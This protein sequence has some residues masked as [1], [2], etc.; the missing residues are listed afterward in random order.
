M[1]LL[2]NMD[3]SDQG[4]LQ[5][6]NVSALELTKKF[7]TPL[8]VLD[9]EEIEERAIAYKEALKE[10]YPG[11]FQILYA[12]KAFA[13]RTLFKMME[14]QGFGL[15]IVSGGELYRAQKADF[16]A[17]KIYFHGNNKTPE[18]IDKALASKIGGFFV[19]NFQEASLLNRKAAE[20]NQRV[21]VMIRIKPGISA[22]THEYMMTGQL[23]SKFGVGIEN[24]R[25]YN[26]IEEILDYDNLQLTGLHAHIGSQI[27]ETEAFEKLADIIFTF[28]DD[29]RD[30]MNM[31]FSRINLGGGLG[32]K[33]AEKDPEMSITDFIALL[34]E[35]INRQAEKFNYPLPEL[36][37]EPGRSIIGTAGTTLYTVGN[38]KKVDESKKYISI[39]GGMTDN[40]R[41]SLYD[42]EYSAFLAN[43]ADTSPEEVVTVAG[44]CC[45][46]GDI[47]IEDIELP[48]A[49][50]GDVLAVPA[51][52]AYTYALANNYNEIPRPAVVLVKN[53]ESRVI[54]QRETYEDL[55]KRDTIPP[56]FQE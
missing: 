32:I 31:K 23:H 19:D 40:I 52:G 41:P 35:K 26:L 27:Y 11:D 53:G 33:Q 10:Y 15:D 45:E 42:A 55:I 14:S 37:L 4:I 8:L 17:G 3:I 25:A 39:N 7:G 21:E 18:E 48:V 30:K 20:F 56:K 51:T 34:C 38:I 24:G 12:S 9:E 22:H 43:K 29:V 54:E 6:G 16:P 47:L 50:P 5:I 44:K 49:E 36:I 28:M 13:N 2:G 46:T 1:H